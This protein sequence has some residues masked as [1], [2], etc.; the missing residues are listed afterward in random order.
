MPTLTGA[1]CRTPSKK[2]GKTSPPP[3]GRCIVVDLINE[4]LMVYE[5]GRMA[6]GVRPVKGGAPTD[7]S[8][9]GVFMVYKRLRHHTSSKYPYP[10]GNM[11][12]AL[13]F[14]VLPRTL[15]E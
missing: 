3:L 8:T 6:F 9:R 14:H 2:P 15:G 5:N 12:F 7:P 1:T 13:F 4:H 11:D 10:P